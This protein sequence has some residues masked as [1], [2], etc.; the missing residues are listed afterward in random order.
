MD[1]FDEVVRGCYHMFAED[2]GIT[3][4]LSS[5]QRK[6]SG[7][8]TMKWSGEEVRPTFTVSRD[9]RHLDPLFGPTISLQLYGDQPCAWMCGTKRRQTLDQSRKSR[10]VQL[11]VQAESASNLMRSN[12]RNLPLDM[13]ERDPTHLALP[14]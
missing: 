5:P 7:K 2:S 11:L 4:A 14:S 13:G 12:H 6:R 8:G 9:E 10:P 3:L 1:R